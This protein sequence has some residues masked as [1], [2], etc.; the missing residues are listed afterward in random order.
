[1]F[2]VNW[3]SKNSV[4]TVDTTQLLVGF[5]GNAL[6]SKFQMGQWLQVLSVFASPSRQAYETPPKK[7]WCFILAG[8]WFGAFFY[9]SI[10][11]GMSSSQLT[12]SSFSEGLNHQPVRGM[13]FLL[14]NCIRIRTPQ[15]WDPFNSL[16][17][18][19]DVDPNSGDG[20]NFEAEKMGKDGKKQRHL[21]IHS[22][23]DLLTWFQS[24]I[25][26]AIVCPL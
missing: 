13:G 26:P 25:F 17:I 10:Q 4:Q 9:F 24:N 14:L 1:M 20:T 21:Y 16:E 23:L 5:S 12:K 3:G 2:W 19:G 7:P 8:W 22:Y 11:L 6:A 15:T 18:H